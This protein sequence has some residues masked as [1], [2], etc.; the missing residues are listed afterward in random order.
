MAYT[1]IHKIT[2]TLNAALDYISGDKE[3]D[4]SDEKVERI[5]RLEGNDNTK[6]LEDSLKD[7]L[8]YAYRDK[9][10]TL[11]FKTYTSYN[12]CF[13]TEGETFG[14]YIINHSAFWSEEKKNDKNK[15]VTKNNQEVIAWHLIQSFEESIRPEVANE[16]G[17]RLVDKIIPDYPCQISTHTNTEHTHNHIIFSAWNIDGKKYNANNKAVDLVRKISDRLCFEYGLHVLEN[18]KEMKLIKYK[19]SDGNLHYYEP[20]DRK[21]EKISQR[22]NGNASKDDVN[23]YRNTYQYE[24]KEN[25]KDTVRNT[26]RKDIDYWI[27]QVSS[28]ESLLERLREHGYKIRDKKKN[29]DWLSYI[30]YK[31]MDAERGVRDSSLSEDGYYKRENLESVI[32]ELNRNHNAE[33]E[34]KISSIDNLKYFDRYVVGEFDPFEDIDEHTRLDQDVSRGY[35]AKRRSVVETEVIKDIRKEYSNTENKYYKGFINEIASKSSA[36]LTPEE[37][38]LLERIR[39]RCDCLHFIEK[40]DIKYFDTIQNRIMKTSEQVHNM[41]AA[42][43][44]LRKAINRDK[45]LLSLPEKIEKLSYKIAANKNSEGYMNTEY[46]NDVKTINVY[47]KMLRDKGLVSPER[48]KGFENKIRAS[49]KK[50]ISFEERVE[51]LNKEMAQY[52]DFNDYIKAIGFEYEKEREVQG[53]NER[54]AQVRKGIL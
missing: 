43:D 13:P 10:N 6:S 4:I 7:S 27:P 35:Y 1:E 30:T 18:T 44:S 53:L 9:E 19:D 47:K 36:V 50:L 24:D 49:E 29:G 14:K 2:A 26:V 32:E 17:R 41:N 25:K 5:N 3:E 33:H 28:F 12:S 38:K 20:T 42:L 21:N 54:N 37:E 40:K 48:L 8:D 46:A 16:I 11:I 45:K 22:E 39:F 15:K 51:E 31:P 52:N 34:N 23:S